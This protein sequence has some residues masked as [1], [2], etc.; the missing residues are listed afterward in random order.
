MHKLLEHVTCTPGTK[1]KHNVSKNV[2][3]FIYMILLDRELLYKIVL[4][5][6]Q[7]LNRLTKN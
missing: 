1:I 2:K 4:R 6:P 7:I 3:Y 5:F